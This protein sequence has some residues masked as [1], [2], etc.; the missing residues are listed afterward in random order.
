M[1]SDGNR[2][3]FGG[4]KLIFTPP[5]LN[6][7]DR[8]SPSAPDQRHLDKVLRLKRGDE[9]QGSD[10]RSRVLCRIDRIGSKMEL[11]VAS[12]EPLI[13][14]RK[15]SLAVARIEM[16]RFASA[17]SAAAQMAVREV[18]A[19][20][21]ERA[22]RAPLSMDRLKRVAVESAKQVGCPFLPDLQELPDLSML[23]ERIRGRRAFLL[24]MLAP[25]TLLESIPYEVD[26][27]GILLIVGPTG[28][29][30]DGEKKK[31]QAAGAEPA[32][33]CSELL[34]SE[35][36]AIIAMGVAATCIQTSRPGH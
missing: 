30:T 16:P 4:V 13:D 29:L 14:R 20:G 27:G 1:N 11:R 2:G 18:Y 15:I 6:V 34:R 31:L 28:D 3:R 10:G 22:E 21:C 19:F 7:G 9:I 5:N 36:A 35:T 8:F 25:R 26:D 23:A 24:D 32:Q 33:L 12:V 17:V